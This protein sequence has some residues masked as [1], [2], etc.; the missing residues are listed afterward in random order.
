M[1]SLAFQLLQAKG[2]GVL[3]RRGSQL[4]DSDEATTR[5]GNIWT[6]LPFLVSDMTSYWTNDYV[7]MSLSQR[8]NLASFLAKLACIGLNNDRLSG[9]ALIVLEMLWRQGDQ[10]AI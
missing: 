10:L 7:T 4:P 8:L 2:Q 1:D 5:D 3:M 6:D 9:I